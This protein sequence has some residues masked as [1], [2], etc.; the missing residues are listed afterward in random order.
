MR[1]FLF[2][3]TLI[4]VM[5]SLV[6]S[7]QKP[8]GPNYRSADAP[9]LVAAANAGDPEAML[10]LGLKYSNPKQ[11]VPKDDVQAAAWFRKAAEAGE[12]SAMYYAGIAFWSGRGVTQDMVEAYKWIDLSVKYGNAQLGAPANGLKDGLTRVM[13]PQMINEAKVRGAEWDR[14]FQKKRNQ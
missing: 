1:R 2:A 11:D 12:P 7:A 10:W 4:G 9:T 3:L 8:A 6:T 13:T 14:A 5:S